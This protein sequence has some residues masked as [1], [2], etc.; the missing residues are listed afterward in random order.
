MKSVENNNRKLLTN[1]LKQNN[2]LNC[3]RTYKSVT[4]KS[5]KIS[6]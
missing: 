2:T 3:W 6:A 4:T 1:F 5:V